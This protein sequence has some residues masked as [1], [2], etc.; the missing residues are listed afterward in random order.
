MKP[1]VFK[2]LLLLVGCVVCSLQASAQTPDTVVVRD[3]VY[4]YHS[5]PADSVQDVAPYVA[6]LER[7][8]RL[9][10]SLIPKGVKVQYAGNMGMFSAGPM[11]RYGKNKQWETSL[12]LGFVPKHQGKNTLATLT[13]KQ[14]FVPWSIRATE[15]LTIEPLEA[16]LYVNTVLSGHFWTHQPSRYPKGY[17]WFSTRVRPNVFIGQRATLHISD[18]KRK[19]SNSISMFYEI[20]TCDFMIIQRVH[21]S[22]LKLH[23]YLSISLGLQ[24]TWL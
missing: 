15:S 3:T 14:D 9:W 7:Y 5:S 16:G 12:L 17:Y 11:W 18:D 2:T 8:N 13:L 4:I 10:N 21:N 19:F 20:S 1:S 22:S 24:L 6:R 23:D